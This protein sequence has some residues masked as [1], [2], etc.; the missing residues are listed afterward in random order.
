MRTYWVQADSAEAARRLVA[1]N[2]AAAFG[3]RDESLFD[4]IQDDTKTPPTGLIYTDHGG[5]IAIKTLG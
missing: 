5:S 3:A 4:C 1:L 2:V